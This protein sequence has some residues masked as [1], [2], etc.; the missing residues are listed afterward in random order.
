MRVGKIGI[1]VVPRFAIAGM[2][3]PELFPGAPEE[4][5]GDPMDL[6]NFS[7]TR[8]SKVQDSFN[9]CGVRTTIDCPTTDTIS[10]PGT[11]SALIGS[12]CWQ[13]RCTSRPRIRN[14]C[15]VST[16]AISRCSRSINR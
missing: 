16:G 5:T 6:L 14:R 4:L 2:P 8:L 3:L 11:C 10:E 7:Q 12:A 13:D 1:Q 15:H 9:V